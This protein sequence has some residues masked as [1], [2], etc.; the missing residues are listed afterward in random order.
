MWI[1]LIAAFR[2]NQNNFFS[3]LI[4]PDFIS[5]VLFAC[6]IVAASLLGRNKADVTFFMLGF[7]RKYVTVLGNKTV[8]WAYF[9]S[10]LTLADVI[11][12]SAYAC[13]R[14]TRLEIP[15]SW[16]RVRCTVCVLQTM[17]Y[18]ICQMLWTWD[19][20]LASQ[21]EVL[22]GWECESGHEPLPSWSQRSLFLYFLFLSAY[23]VAKAN[24]CKNNLLKM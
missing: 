22:W 15:S 12:Y 18:S 24:C 3:A 7:E 16:S 2:R 23:V 9:Q 13:A 14:C 10:C 1:C 5:L 20:L 21:P 8:T 11:Y 4:S 6:F 19:A 17:V